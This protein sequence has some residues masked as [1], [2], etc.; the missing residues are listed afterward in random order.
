MAE[1]QHHPNEHLGS[2]AADVEAVLA[3]IDR[4]DVVGRIWRRD[5]TVWKS[6]PTEISDRLGWLTITETMRRRVAELTMFA[7]EV[8]RAGFQYVVL[9][10]MGGSSLGPEVLRQTFGSAPGFPRLTVLD[11]V[12]PDRVLEVKEAVDPAK[13]L[14]LFSS[15]SGSTIEPNTCYAYFLNLMEQAVGEDKAGDHFAAITDAG[16]SL[17]ALAA[18][19]GF[20]R[21]F[22]NP[23]DIGGRYS[24]LSYFGLVPAALMGIDVDKLL[25]RADRMKECCIRDVSAA[26][27]PAARLG[28]IMGRLVRHGRDKATLVT[29]PSISSFG[30]W[31][32]Q[33]L[34]ESTGKE[35]TGIVP[36]AGEPLGMPGEYGD[37]RLFVYLR[38]EGDDNEETDFAMESLQ[39]AGHP[40]VRLDLQDKYDIGAEFFRWEF[41]TAVA[42]YI[43]KVNPF[44]QPDVQS[45]KDMTDAVLERVR[46]T[47][48]LEGTMGPSGSLREFL[49]Q[50]NKGDY[51]AVL[52]YAAETPGVNKA[53]QM[54]RRK[55]MQRYAIATTVG[56][57]P[58]YLHSTGQL[59]KGGPGLGLFL[60]LTA[61]HSREV[62]VPG[63]GFGFGLLADAQAAGDMQALRN[64]GQR[65]VRVHLGSRPEDGIN[66]LIEELS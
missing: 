42:G 23:S 27:N 41:A 3:N 60:Q 29:S 40:E 17:E 21:V 54:L 22:L 50:G 24:V 13:T 1:G 45:A 49:E 48:S 33:L 47:G 63:Y 20:R 38:L 62:E 44:D 46:R 57:G 31:A 11:S 66:Q 32:E 9:L 53:L 37:D 51:L 10:G 36:V 14:F 15:K 26:R 2:Y 64:A 12:V 56:Y 43:L 65:A 59:H 35:G 16:T 61:D 52:V 39:A 8:R 25:S 30:L 6:D 18:A 28:A 4:E 7:D 5:H 34:A 58:R 19:H 55:V